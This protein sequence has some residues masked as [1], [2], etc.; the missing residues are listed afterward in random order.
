[1][2]ICTST[3]V[4]D[5]SWVMVDYA[6]MMNHMAM[7]YHAV[8]TGYVVVVDHSQVLIACRFLSHINVE[9]YNGNSKIT[10]ETKLSIH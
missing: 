2:S 1:M 4:D 6:E 9:R 7:T 8:V 10:Y 3:T 5:R